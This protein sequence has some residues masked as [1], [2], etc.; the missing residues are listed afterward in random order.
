MSSNNPGNQ[1]I[2]VSLCTH[3]Y[4]KFDVSSPPKKKAHV[5]PSP[6]L[7]QF[8]KLLLDGL[9]ENKRREGI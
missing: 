8:V 6:H 1:P 7:T 2:S 5:M 4:S 3:W 9:R